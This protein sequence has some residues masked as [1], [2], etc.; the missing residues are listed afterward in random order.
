[1]GL[2]NDSHISCTAE[3]G[4]GHSHRVGVTVSGQST[5]A[6]NFLL[7]ASYDA[8]EILTMAPRSLG[9][10]QTLS[11]S[12]LNFGLPSRQHEISVLLGAGK[13]AIA[14]G[15]VRVVEAHH[16]IECTL[17]QNMTRK[18]NVE[19]NLVVS[20]LAA[21]PSGGGG[22]TTVSIITGC[23]PGEYLQSEDE[24]CRPC[25]SPLHA[26][27]G[28]FA[29]AASCTCRPG[30]FGPPGGDCYPCP[31]EFAK[32]GGAS[33]LIPQ[34]FALLRDTQEDSTN[35]TAGNVTIKKCWKGKAAC[36]PQSFTVSSDR[37]GTLS[38]HETTNA[39]LCSEG[40][41]GPLCSRCAQ[42]HYAVQNLCRQCGQSLSWQIPLYSLALVAF[43]VGLFLLPIE[44]HRADL[45]PISRAAI[46]VYTLQFL[47]A[48]GNI[49]VDWPEQFSSTAAGISALQIN[50]ELVG[51]ECW[52]R[53]GCSY[54]CKTIVFLVFPL[55]IVALVWALK[56]LL[57]LIVWTFFHFDLHFAST[58]TLTTY[59]HESNA[60]C[61]RAT[62]VVLLC[63]Y[64]LLS[65]RM[66][67]GF[68]CIELDGE[69][70]LVSR[71]DIRCYSMEHPLDLLYLGIIIYPLGLFVL[72]CFVLW[73][74]RNQL[75]D[76][77]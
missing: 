6:D 72:L 71:L 34:G 65:E 22:N 9:P 54:R 44:R 73:T 60:R 38:F 40:F 25:P 76:T 28:G 62:C 13:D 49:S 17:P 66:F 74:I 27:P 2:H 21:V 31:S 59:L 42:G 52:F 50:P 55:V 53:K 75:D 41:E 24:E 4:Q 5:A 77:W 8:P 7:L 61:V 48:M 47:S 11:L 23:R 16:R 37:L 26:S 70:R 30:S 69:E 35:T 20:G 56:A 14:C 33:I 51:P 1:M 46:I 39:S 63:A 36:N 15:N 32:C 12:G 57:S 58:R 10:G 45:W 43:C 19:L 3:P 67:Q 29:S 64:L 18:M 68:N